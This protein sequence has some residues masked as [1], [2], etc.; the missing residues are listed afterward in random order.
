MINSVL[1]SDATL[2]RYYFNTQF[3]TFSSRNLKESE[4]LISSLRSDPIEL[5]SWRQ[6]NAS[7]AEMFCDA[8]GLEHEQ[9]LSTAIIDKWQYSVATVHLRGHID[10]QTICNCVRIYSRRNL[11]IWQAKRHRAVSISPHTIGTN[12][13]NQIPADDSLTNLSKAMSEGKEQE[14]FPKI[15][16]GSQLT[17]QRA[18]IRGKCSL[19]TLTPYSSLG[20]CSGA[21]N[22]SLSIFC[23]HVIQY[24]DHNRQTCDSAQRFIGNLIAEF[25]QKLTRQCSGTLLER[26]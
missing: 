24:T 8:N 10:L 9:G 20:G 4:A 14:V 25:F 6:K 18:C 21:A 26:S 12:E 7:G 15:I 22:W 19:H 2:L 13:I 16:D 23:E 17:R 3:S 5:L 11:T 1:I